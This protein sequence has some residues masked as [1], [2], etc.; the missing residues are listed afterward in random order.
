MTK[1][2][3]LGYFVTTELSLI[4]A[5]AIWELERWVEPEAEEHPRRQEHIHC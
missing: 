4:K 3:S 2:Y 1:A 5:E